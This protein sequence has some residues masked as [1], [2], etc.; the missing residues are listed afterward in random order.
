MKKLLL[1]GNEAFDAGPPRT[2]RGFFATISQN[3][4]PDGRGSRYPLIMNNL[5]DGCLEAEYAPAARREL[6]EI[7]RGLKMVPVSHV[8]PGP[9]AA[10]GAGP[11]CVNPSA[12]N[13]R[14]YYHRS[15]RTSCD[16]GAP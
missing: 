9:P 11:I 2:I 4:E 6:E 15:E 13:A 12:A 14:D 16:R 3:L 1:V 10:A 8:A 7:D 5:H